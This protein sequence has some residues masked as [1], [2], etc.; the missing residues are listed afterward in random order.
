VYVSRVQVDIHLNIC[1]PSIIMQGLFDTPFFPHGDLKNEGEISLGD[2]PLRKGES[3]KGA[4]FLF[5]TVKVV[6]A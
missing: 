3:Q 5:P 4:I 2:L 6:A 1:D